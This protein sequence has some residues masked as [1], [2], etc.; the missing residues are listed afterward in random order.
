ML[1]SKINYEETGIVFNMQRFSIHDG[2]G[3]RTIA[4]L[5]GCPLTCD[6]CSNPE[7]H[8]KKPEVMF[9]LNNCKGCRKCEKVCA[10]GAIDF[11][12]PHRVNQDICTG[13]GKCVEVCFPRG[14]VMSGNKR[15]VEEVIKDLKKDSTQYRRSGGGI[16]LSGGE[17]LL[18]QDF[19]EE[20]LKACKALGWH[21]AME[22]TAFAKKD[23]IEKVIPWV[24]LVL[25]DIKSIDASQHKRYTGVN[26]E[27]I[28]ENAKTIAQLGV[29]IIV[30]VPVIPMFNADEKSIRDIANF[31]KSLGVVKELHLL[32]YHRLGVNKYE[33]IGKHYPIRP[34]IKTPSEDTMM[35]LKGIVESVGIKCSVGGHFGEN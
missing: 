11:S 6:W 31:T 19:S 3:I 29:E 2:P 8:K 14:L 27:I 9:N 18:Q 23:V 30:R 12:L 7:S 17:P 22:T 34:N 4:F 32:P 25:L 28:L 26:N 21:T 13:C 16:T 33:C 10:L 15:M 35:K 1:N 24:D 5:K 20:L